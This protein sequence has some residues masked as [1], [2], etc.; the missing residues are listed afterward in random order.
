MLFTCRVVVY[1]HCWVRKVQTFP[2]LSLQY[3]SKSTIST[4]LISF[5]FISTCS[6]EESV[7]MLSSLNLKLLKGMFP[8]R[9]PIL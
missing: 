2:E 8:P 7:G 9:I 6:M 1:V 5:F 3:V 4:K